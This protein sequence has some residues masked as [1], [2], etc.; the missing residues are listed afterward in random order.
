MVIPIFDHAQPK[1]LN[2]L[3]AFLMQKMQKISSFNLFILEK[4]SISWPDLPHPFLD[5]SQSKSFDQALI[6]VNLHQHAK[7]KAISLICSRNMVD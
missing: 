2:Q 3:L 6:H 5:H 4:W 1:L 7:N